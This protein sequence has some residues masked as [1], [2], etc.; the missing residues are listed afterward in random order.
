MV[1]HAQ[2]MTAP[3]SEEAVLA[4][5]LSN[6]G[7]AVRKCRDRGLPPEAFSDP[8]NVAVFAFAVSRPDPDKDDALTLARGMQDARILDAAG[9]WER[10]TQIQESPVF[11]CVEAHAGIIMSK[12][13]ARTISAACRKA[14]ESVEF[15]EDPDVVA[16]ALSHR[17]EDTIPSPEATKDQQID[18]A[19]QEMEDTASGKKVFIPF[20]WRR[21][22][23]RT[24]GLPTGAVTPLLGRDKK[25]KSR[26]AMVLAAHWAREGIPTL[27]FAFEDGRSRYIQGLASTL[28]QYDSF[29]VR[30]NP[31]K[32]YFDKARESMDEMRKLPV[33]VVDSPMSA[34]RICDC[35][36]MYR[37]MHGIRAVVIDGFKDI[38]ESK[39]ENRT[40]AENHMFETVKKGAIRSQCAVLCI[41]HPH[42]VDDGVW[43]AKRNIRGSKQ[44]SHSARMFLV[45]QDKGIPESIR[46]AYKLD[47]TEGII[48][49][50]CQEASYGERAVVLL[51]PELERGRFVEIMPEPD[52]VPWLNKYD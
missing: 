37:R 23:S 18:E 47:S 49:L 31:G 44:R 16:S 21:F 22:Q 4:A 40:T 46:T 1:E 15:G 13:R 6:P 39:G 29:G 34:E 52:T 12:H 19:M 36:A 24:F 32:E 35:M 2:T 50:D 5:I 48:A 27:V 17:I 42:D 8:R 30:R 3:E 41:E 38:I 45:F 9:G 51:R 33:H 26:L 14:A 10:L 43:L 28:G 25:G 20:P 7:D 11:G